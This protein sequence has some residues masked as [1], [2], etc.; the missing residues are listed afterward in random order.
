[1]LV[2]WLVVSSDGIYLGW[3]ICAINWMY[4]QQWVWMRV[5]GYTCLGGGSGG[6][7]KGVKKLHMR[8]KYLDAT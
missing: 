8:Q 3:V 2:E 6:K 4:K 1:M 7:I 5:S